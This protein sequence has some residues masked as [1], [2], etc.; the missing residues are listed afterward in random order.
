MRPEFR[1]R[2]LD[3]GVYHFP[4]V[5]ISRITSIIIMYVI[6]TLLVVPVGLMC[7]LSISAVPSPVEV[8]GILLVFT[9]LFCGAMSALTRA[10]PSELFAASSA[11][12]A[13]LVVFMSNVDIV[14]LHRQL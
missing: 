6:I 3:E 5:L 1:L 9:L 14:F 12:C 4:P 2:A 8:V 10:R 11:Y 7:W 13:V